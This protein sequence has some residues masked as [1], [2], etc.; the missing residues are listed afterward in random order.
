MPPSAKLVGA[1]IEANSKRRTRVVTNEELQAIL[2]ELARRD[3]RAYRVTFFCALTCCRFGEAAKLEWIDVDL[4][5]GRAYSVK[6]KND[7]DR[8]IPVSGTLVDLLRE[9]G[10]R[11]RPC[12]QNTKGQRYRQPPEAFR[13]AVAALVIE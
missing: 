5:S 1:T 7:E 3:M 2:E 13:K 4:G 8:A 12:R 10:P 6:T 9:I 11:G